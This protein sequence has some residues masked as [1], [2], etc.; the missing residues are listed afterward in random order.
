MFNLTDTLKTC[1]Q[2]RL[3]LVL[4]A[5]Y[6]KEVFN[7]RLSVYTASSVYLRAIY[8]LFKYNLTELR[9]VCSN[10]RPQR[11][12][13]CIKN[14]PYLRTC[15]AHLWYRIMILPKFKTNSYIILS[16]TQ[17]SNW[18][19]TSYDLR[20]WQWPLPTPYQYSY[21]TCLKLFWVK[22]RKNCH[23]CVFV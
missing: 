17:S 12:R 2:K 9:F 11:R 7:V 14:R 15:L 3:I 19:Q 1:V 4:Y 16:I 13:G 18:R 5:H 22:A 8:F 10:M 20:F 21:A 23:C 6:Y